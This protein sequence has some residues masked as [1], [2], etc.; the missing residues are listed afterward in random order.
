M[1]RQNFY[2]FPRSGAAIFQL[3]RKQ[4]IGKF[5][6]AVGGHAFQTHK[7][8]PALVSAVFKIDIVPINVG[9]FMFAGQRGDID[10]TGFAGLIQAVHKLGC[11]IEMPHVIGVQLQ[12]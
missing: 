10:D 2:V 11:Q 7:F 8:P 3:L 12:L 5:T 4:Q 6:L 1:C 9:I